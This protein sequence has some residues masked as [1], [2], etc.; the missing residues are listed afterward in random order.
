M[1]VGRDA[2]GMSSRFGKRKCLS[3]IFS[4]LGLA[5][6]NSCCSR[7]NTSSLGLISFLGVISPLSPLYHRIVEFVFVLLW[8]LVR[9]EIRE[10][11]DGVLIL[12]MEDC[13]ERINRAW[14]E[15]MIGN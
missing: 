10:H 6:S 11:D 8:L 5:M 15:F 2:C 12:L 1:L 9:M 7:L 14:I 13:V 4:Y 3:W